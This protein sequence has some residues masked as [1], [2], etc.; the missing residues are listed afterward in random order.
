MWVGCVR[1]VN[2]GI[3]IVVVEGAVVGLEAEA[4]IIEVWALEV[5]VEVAILAEAAVIRE[6]IKTSSS[7]G[8]PVPC[9]PVLA[10]E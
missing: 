4:V 3:V 6:S 2:E 8:N 1:R 7:R 9:L 5:S 10:P